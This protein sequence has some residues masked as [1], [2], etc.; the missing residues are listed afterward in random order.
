MARQE[1]SFSSA[2]YLNGSLA[3]NPLLEVESVRC[4]LQMCA[5][6][7]QIQGRNSIYSLSHFT[8]WGTCRGLQPLEPHTPTSLHLEPYS[9]KKETGKNSL[10]NHCSTSLHL[11]PAEPAVDFSHC[12]CVFVCLCT[13][14]FVYLCTCVSVCLSACVVVYL[15][16]CVLSPCVCVYLSTCTYMCTCVPVYFFVY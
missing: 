4:S 6:S 5:S 12:S 3:T 14:V 10:Y 16:I 15:C 1:G 9:N 2:N 13:F 8:S 7:N 11:E